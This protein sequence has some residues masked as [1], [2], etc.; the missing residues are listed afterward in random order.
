MVKMIKNGWKRFV[1]ERQ[2]WIGLYLLK[3][4]LALVISL[5]ALAVVQAQVD[6]SL[7]ATPLLHSW[8]LA[9]IWELLQAK[10]AAFGSLLTVLLFYTILVMLIRQFLNGGIYSTYLG[11][12]RLTRKEFFG[13]CGELFA[14]HLKVS[15]L[16]LIMY[17]VLLGV[18]MLVASI[19]G[20]VL[21][22]LFPD[23]PGVVLVLWLV[24]VCLF[25]I[26]GVA[27][28]DVFRSAATLYPGES[29][30]ATWKTSLDFFRAHWVQIVG[31][32]LLMY[33]PFVV[34]WLLI[35][36]TALVAIGGL[37]SKLGVLIELALFQSCSFIRTGQSLL[38]TASVADSYARTDAD[39]PLFPSGE[40]S[41][42]RTP[43]L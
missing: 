21:S 4:F 17:A 24:V 13:R 6:Q 23:A 8:S 27:F 36:K 20:A 18:G 35:E 43:V 14:R 7:Y 28:S 16:M 1:A 22:R 26:P 39:N 11:R 33:V 40:V 25:M 2:V 37:G 31:A 9:V 10:P 19:L 3:L 15:G 42:D 38:F 30:R 5:A 32:F 29:T 12:Y 34:L 41:V